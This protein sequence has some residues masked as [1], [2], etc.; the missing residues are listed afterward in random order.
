MSH[1]T[2]NWD[3]SLAAA[4]RTREQANGSVAAKMMDCKKPQANS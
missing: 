1:K 3:G 2:L 4:S